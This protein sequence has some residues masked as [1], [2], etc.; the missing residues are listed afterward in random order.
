MRN[1]RGNSIAAARAKASIAPLTMLAEETGDNRSLGSTP[2]MSVI[3]PPSR[4]A[5]RAAKVR[6]TWPISLLVRPKPYEDSA[7][8]ATEMALSG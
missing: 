3:E 7:I 6:L 5:S 8:E 4:N 2:A 1:P